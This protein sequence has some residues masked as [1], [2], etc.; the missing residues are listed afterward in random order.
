MR[1]RVTRRSTERCLGTCIWS[2]R[3]NMGDTGSP[4]DTQRD[5][6]RHKEVH[7]DARETHRDTGR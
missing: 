6:G 1:Q 4:R 2:H 5:T 3:E 7:G